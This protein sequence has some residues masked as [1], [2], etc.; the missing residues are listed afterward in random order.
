MGFLS[1]D[2]RGSRDFLAA[3]KIISWQ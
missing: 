3:T 2:F 1:I